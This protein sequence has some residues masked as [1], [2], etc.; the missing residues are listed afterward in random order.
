MKTEEASGTVNGVTPGSS[1][2]FREA[3][4]R[5]QTVFSSLLNPPAGFLSNPQRVL[6]LNTGDR[7]ALLQVIGGTRE[8][9]LANRSGVQVFSSIQSLSGDLLVLPD[10]SSVSI[11][12]TSDLPAVGSTAQTRAELLDLRGIAIGGNA[13]VQFTVN[14]EAAFNNFVGF[15]AVTDENGGIDTTGDGVAD[16]RPVD[17]VCA[18]EDR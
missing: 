11:R 4:Q 3:L 9:F 17:Q 15:Y 16:V 12:G 6:S 14:R 10:G 5:S 1:G 18:V 7:F 2:Y 13:R 8:D